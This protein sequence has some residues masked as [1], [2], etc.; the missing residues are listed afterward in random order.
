MFDWCQIFYLCANESMKIN[1]QIYWNV[2]N[3]YTQKTG[4]SILCIGQEWN[5]HNF[6]TNKINC[7]INCTFFFINWL[8]SHFDAQHAVGVSV[9]LNTHI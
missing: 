1:L 8:T 3:G 7:A 6:H 2:L 5:S 4:G 9:V